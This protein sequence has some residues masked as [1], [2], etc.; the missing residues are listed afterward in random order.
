MAIDLQSRPVPARRVR[1]QMDPVDGE[2]VLL[3]PE[4]LLRLNPTAYEIL[5]RCD[6]KTSVEGIVA[7]LADE[8]EASPETLRADVIECLTQFH[9]RQLIVLE[10]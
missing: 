7:S 10:A 4:G 3:Y 5:S 8:Y 2:P 6:G 1:L 9:G